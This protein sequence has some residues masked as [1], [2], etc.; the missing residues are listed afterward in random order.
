MITVVKKHT[1]IPLP[2]HENE[3]TLLIKTPKD[4]VLQPYVIRNIYLGLEFIIPQGYIFKILK[5]K[6]NQ[7]WVFVSPYIFPLWSNGQASYIPMVSNKLCFIGE[8][9]FL[10]RFE[11]VPALAL[12]TGN[13]KTQI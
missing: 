13:Y 7:P 1:W 6:N 3:N 10:C 4:I 5:T 12:F 11:L 9:E 8:N 2:E